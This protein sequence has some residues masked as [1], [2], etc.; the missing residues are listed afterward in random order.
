[1]LYKKSDITICIIE[2]SSVVS[3]GQLSKCM[4]LLSKRTFAGGV[5][6]GGGGTENEKMCP[7]F[8]WMCALF[9]LSSVPLIFNS[10]SILHNC[11]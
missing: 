5:E 6:L 9:V 11:I 4:F 2:A 7:F 1:M 3:K 8:N 10:V